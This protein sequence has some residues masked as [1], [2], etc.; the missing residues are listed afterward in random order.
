LIAGAELEPVCEQ[1]QV[2]ATALP[3]NQRLY[4]GL[5]DSFSMR[6]FAPSAGITGHDHFFDAFAKFGGTD[7]RHTGEWIDEVATRAASQNIQYLELM[8]T[9]TWRRLNTITR[10]MTWREDLKSLKDELMVKGL[11]DDIPAA[12]AFLDEADA[13]RR[14]HGHCGTPD[15]S[16]ACLVE[17][18]YI[19]QVFRNTPKESVLAQTLFGC[20]GVS[21]WA[22]PVEAKL[23]AG[24][25]VALV[26]GGN[27]AGQAVAYLA[28]RVKYLH[29]VVRGEDLEA[30]MS[31]YL[32]D[33]IKALPNVEL[34]TNTEIV[35]LEGDG[36]SGLTG[37][38]F[39]CRRTGE[40]H[41]CAL[42]HLFLFIGAD[43][44]AGWLEDCVQVDDKGFVVTGTE[45]ANG[46]GAARRQAL[47]LETSW[48]GVFAIGDVRAGS[49][50]RVA[51][52][53]GEG[54]AVV[55]QIHSVLA[56]E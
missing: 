39:R 23:C 38:V 43:P 22:S 29:L 51:A 20:A 1:D 8:V 30:S 27:S 48:P 31:Q 21:Y 19:Y 50:K 5:V 32:I 44:N 2:P 47:P 14:E 28:P 56:A 26:G 53:V 12:R 4:N 9:P 54:A 36:A 11:L 37:A 7:P 52:A 6:G 34:H 35:G 16:P 33:R 55:A 42:R 24:E 41:A 3:K 25:E 15:E 18:R 46:A 17:T 40:T 49:T 13:L 10:D 45:L